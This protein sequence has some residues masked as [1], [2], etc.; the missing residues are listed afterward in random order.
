MSQ[1]NPAGH[2]L[3][4]SQRDHH[5][6]RLQGTDAAPPLSG[7][8]WNSCRHATVVGAVAYLPQ[9]NWLPS[10]HIRCRMTARLRATEHTRE[11][12]QHGRVPNPAAWRCY[13]PSAQRRPLVAA[14][15]QRIDGLL[16]HRASLFIPE[17]VDEPRIAG[18]IA[19]RR[20]AETCAHIARLWEP[21]LLVDGG[22]RRQCG[23]RSVGEGRTFGD[24]SNF[25]RSCFP[26][27]RLQRY[28]QAG[29]QLTRISR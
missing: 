16:E 14:D 23:R 6:H 27:V 21:D 3:P 5:P 9:R 22:T 11:G 29:L 4:D 25:G 26:L 28:P 24:Q 17:S 18:L 1:A 12:Q 20:Q 7:G 13:S 19:A 10:T 15:Q 8:N 2:S